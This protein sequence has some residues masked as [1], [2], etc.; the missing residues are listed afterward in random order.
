MA[1]GRCRAHLR[2]GVIE[3]RGE[4]L[5]PL[6]M[7]GF[8]PAQDLLRLVRHG[9]PGHLTE[10]HVA[11]AWP[12]RRCHHHGRAQYLARPT[13]GRRPYRRR[14]SAARWPC[15][16]MLDIRANFAV[17]VE[18]NARGSRRGSS[19]RAS[20]GPRLFEVDVRPRTVGLDLGRRA[21]CVGPTPSPL[22]RC[23]SRRKSPR[24]AGCEGILRR[25]HAG[26]YQAWTRFCAGPSCSIVT[27][28]HR[29]PARRSRGPRRARPGCLQQ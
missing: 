28:W 11:V 13:S 29:R 8:I 25:L 15:V 18:S 7:G 26:R 12:R 2:R 27:R 21:S 4:S 5:T 1:T 17:A 19:H 23:R 9:R 16:S 22:P 24:H 6:P 20:S 3:L 10:G 14:S